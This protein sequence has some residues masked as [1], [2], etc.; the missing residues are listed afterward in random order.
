MAAQ[1]RTPPGVHVVEQDSFSGTVTQ[2]PT[3]VPVFIGYTEAAG[4]GQAIPLASMADFVRVFGGAPSPRFA[5]APAAASPLPPCAFDPAHPRFN[6][7]YALELFFMNGG[8]NCYVL[9]I[10]AY[11]GGIPAITADAYDGVWT[12]LEK[13]PEPTIVV[14]PDSV[15]LA[16]DAWTSVALQALLHC[17]QMENRVAIF[18]LVNGCYP[19]DGTAAD[20]VQAF[21]AAGVKGED[22]NKY[23][24]AYYPWINT[25]LVDPATVDFSWLND[26]GIGA[27]RKDLLTE[28][29][30]LFPPIGSGQDAKLAAYTAL[31]ADVATGQA[32][33]AIRATHQAVQAASPLYRQTIQRLAASVNLLPPGGAMA[34]VYALTDSTRGVWQSPANTGITGAVS[35]AQPVS[36]TLQDQL[37][38]PL[39]GLAVNAIRTFPNFGLLVWGARTMAGNS[40][41]WRYIS[42]RRTCMMLEQSIRYAMQPYVFQPN[43]QLTWT[44]LQAEV[45]NFLT[46]MWKEGALQGSKPADAYS[47]SV[48]LGTTMTSEDILRGYLNMTVQ[49]ALVHPA[50]F[51]VLTFQQQMQTGA[52]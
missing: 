16:A 17:H 47:V 51:I 43:E 22:F 48:G 7:Y 32:A 25:S 31:L 39:N 2:A 42:V 24:I 49:V 46:E 1:D 40:D 14:M 4:N 36:D 8:S 18:D 38:L 50:E 12:V 5:Y 20:P 45:S 19:V 27:L 41:D 26:A 28:A 30:T 35:P 34:G 29:P 15:L 9:S 37:N 33:D 3:A 13:Y 6:L 44:A 21:Y 10:G 11:G 52:A 23:G